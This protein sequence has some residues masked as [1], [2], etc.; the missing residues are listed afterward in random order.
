MRLLNQSL[1]FIALNITTVEPHSIGE[2]MNVDVSSPLSMH[3]RLLSIGPL[4]KKIILQ[5]HSTY[6]H[7]VFKCQIVNLLSKMDFAIKMVEYQIFDLILC[8]VKN[9]SFLL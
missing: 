5:Y 8:Q 4:H 1:T 7:L 9:R 2:G 3:L 6:S